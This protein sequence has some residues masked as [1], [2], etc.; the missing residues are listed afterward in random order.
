MLCSSASRAAP[1][2]LWSA[3]GGYAGVLRA[4]R[5]FLCILGKGASSSDLMV[6]D[7]L[8]SGGPHSLEG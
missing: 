3:R 6:W 5:V 2:M 8:A 4:R 7:V 1:G